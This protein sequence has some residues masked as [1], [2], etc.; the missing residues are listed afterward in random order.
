MMLT[1][2]ALTL[3]ARTFPLESFGL[4]TITRDGDRFVDGTGKPFDAVNYSRFKHGD[5]RAAIQYGDQ[6]AQCLAGRNFMKEPT[7]ITAS[8]YKQLSTA[9]EV[10]ARMARMKLIGKGYNPLLGRI[11][12]AH[13]T[14]GDYASMSAD[15][16]TLVMQENGIS[17]DDDLFR[18]RHVVV[19]D[20]IKITGAHERSIVKLFKNRDIL[21]L[22]HLY[23]VCMDSELSAREPMVESMLNH[24][25]VNGLERLSELIAANPVRYNFNA[26][27]TK[28][29]LGAEVSKLEGFLS[30]LRD[31]HIRQLYAG[32]IGDGYNM[33]QPYE[34]GFL[35][36]QA[37]AINRG[38]VASFTA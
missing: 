1:T 9:A 37:E 33:M 28:M 36:L 38:V 6:V 35:C 12:R 25:W 7:V 24:T 13:L 22:T 16:R 4:K 27:T 3:E 15:E 21:S 19:V 32:T 26:R 34:A 30:S 8:A 5:V 20:D 17:L 23:V 31:W 2:S 29:V 11:H 10:V 18:R 14:C